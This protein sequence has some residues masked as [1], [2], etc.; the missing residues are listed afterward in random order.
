MQQ[1]GEDRMTKYYS[2]NRAGKEAERDAGIADIN[3]MS[4]I[5]DDQ[6]VTFKF[7]LIRYVRK[8]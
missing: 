7:K 5:T 2:L 8:I 6:L 4:K 3:T 1:R